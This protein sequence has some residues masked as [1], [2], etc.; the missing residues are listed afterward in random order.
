MP[1]PAAPAPL[2]GGR[3][4]SP[5]LPHSWPPAPNQPLPPPSPPKDRGPS[6]LTGEDAQAKVEV[7]QAPRESRA[8]EAERGEDAPNHHY[9]ARPPAGAQGAAHGTWKEAESRE[10]TP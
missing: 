10:D 1:G 7:Q 4:P 6:P 2:L 3:P 8:E 9:G 5:P